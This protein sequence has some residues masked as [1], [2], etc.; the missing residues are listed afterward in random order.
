MRIFKYLFWILYRIWFYILVALPI[1]V[2]FPILLVSILKESWYPYFF[3]LARFWAK[4]ILTGMGFVWKIEREEIPET[5]KSYMFVANHTSMADIMLMLVSVKNPFV[6]V[7]KKELAKIP[8]FGFFYKR[9][10]I[11]VD[12]NSE[13]SRKAVFLRAQRRLKQGLSICIFPEGGVPEEHIVLDTFKDGAFRL[14]IN[15][16]IPIVPMTFLD[17]KKR[18]SYTFFSGGPGKMRV[19]IHP[20]IET[21]GLT[22]QDTKLINEKTRKLILKTL[23]MDNN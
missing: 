20:F 22:I 4:F 13:K 9:T 14:A 17:N 7:G 18:F 5:D 8:L 23:K 16:Q 1:I 12:R 2:L 19:K 21:K 6:F 11:L 3:K 10:C 15:H